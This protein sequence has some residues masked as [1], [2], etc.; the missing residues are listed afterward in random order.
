MRL[1]ALLVLQWNGCS[2]L[3]IRLTDIQR[4]IDFLRGMLF[5]KSLI[6]RQHQILQH[7]NAD[8]SEALL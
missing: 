5:D 4:S 8:I 3:N 6:D 7:L 2:S 1:C